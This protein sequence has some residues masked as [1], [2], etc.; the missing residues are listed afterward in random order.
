M[1]DRKIF[2]FFPSPHPEEPAVNG[3]YQVVDIDAK[4]SIQSGFVLYEDVDGRHH[5][6][7][8][9]KVDTCPVL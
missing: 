1:Y 7:R 8:Y 4:V 6:A 3:S 9:P 2:G 5:N